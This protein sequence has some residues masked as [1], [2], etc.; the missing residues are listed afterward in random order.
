MGRA[1]MEEWGLGDTNLGIKARANARELV[2]RM[3][4]RVQTGRSWEG[5]F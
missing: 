5:W 3:K 1:K 2:E 4:A